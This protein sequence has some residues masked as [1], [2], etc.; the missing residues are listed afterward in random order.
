MESM[1]GAP[2]PR[3][4]PRSYTNRNDVGRTTPTTP[5]ITRL[6]TGFEGIDPDTPEG[7]Q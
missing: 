7:S 4:V 6:W 3:N 5:R 2:I 1:K